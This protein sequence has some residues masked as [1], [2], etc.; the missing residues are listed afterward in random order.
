MQFVHFTLMA[1][2]FIDTNFGHTLIMYM[3]VYV[4]SDAF[5][6]IIVPSSG[7]NYNYCGTPPFVK[8]VLVVMSWHTG[9][10]YVGE[11]QVLFWHC[12]TVY[13]A[14]MLCVTVLVSTVK[15]F[16]SSFMHS[17]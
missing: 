7:T 11:L 8:Q 14:L 15:T 5:Q 9:R 1:N 3:R 13:V 12:S 10:E 6:Y 17:L 4:L 16:H 2:D